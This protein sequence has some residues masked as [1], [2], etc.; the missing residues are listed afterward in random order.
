MN[1][2]NF[3]YTR[4]SSDEERQVVDQWSQFQR[5]LQTQA[6]D[7][8]MR[9][10]TRRPVHKF[11]VMIQILSAIAGLNMG[12]G[13][14]VGIVFETVG[15]IQYV[16]RVYVALLCAL[17]IFNELEWTLFT[18][19]S[20]ILRNWLSRGM[21][22]AFIGVIGLEENDTTTYRNIEKRGFNVSLQ[23]I[24]SVAWIMVGCGALYSLMGITCMQLVRN[25]LR[26]DYQQRLE[27]ARG[28]RYELR[29]AESQSSS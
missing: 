17:V 26:D 29:N 14:F 20:M 6:E 11:F 21:F 28:I 23:Y 1:R 4:L 5:N 9:N 13:Q 24:K 8:E 25:R 2:L 19:D 7:A 22:Y 12:I 18:R 10:P 27:R 16:L 15:P 3:T